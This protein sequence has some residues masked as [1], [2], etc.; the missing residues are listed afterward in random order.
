MRTRLAAAAIATFPLQ[1]LRERPAVLCQVAQ[2]RF[3]Q[4]V[5]AAVSQAVT[6]ACEL[7]P[8]LQLTRR[9][10]APQL[11]QPLLDVLHQN[12]LNPTQHNSICA[13]A[14]FCSPRG[15]A[16]CGCTFKRDLSNCR[17]SWSVQSRVR[18]RH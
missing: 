7:V 15:A 4:H 10:L 1:P 14:E 13:D 3:A 6:K 2:H 11:R 5:V 16:L 8:L 12:A 18:A 17:L 9:D